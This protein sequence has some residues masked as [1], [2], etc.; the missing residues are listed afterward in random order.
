MIYFYATLIAVGYGGLHF[1][2]RFGSRY[3]FKV[4][5]DGVQYLAAGQGRHVPLPYNLRWMAPRLF[6]DRLLLWCLASWVSMAVLG[7]L[8]AWYFEGDWAIKLFAAAL[9]VGLP[10]IVRINIAMPVLSDSTA[11]AAM[12]AG[13]ACFKRGYF[14]V[15]LGLAGLS[16]TFREAAPIFMALAA[17]SPWPLAGLAAVLLR[18]LQV[19]RWTDAEHVPAMFSEK[20]AEAVATKRLHG[21]DGNKGIWFRGAVMLMPWGICL[22]AVLNPSWQLGL[23]LLAGYGQLIPASDKVR[24]Y[25][26]AFPAVVAAVL[27]SVSK[28]WMLAAVLFHWW[29]PWNVYSF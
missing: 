26:W 28:K 7:P 5:P 13:A 25:Q 27:P 18:Y 24:L 15:G 22:L 6:R 21:L 20:G 2:S 8:A 23:S 29:H 1:V 3:D 14:W 16:A 17:W 9:V 11:I 4:S 10:G 12:L 19:R